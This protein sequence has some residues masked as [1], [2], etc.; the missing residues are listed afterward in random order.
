[1]DNR[2]IYKNYKDNLKS[3]INENSKPYS[4][5]SKLKHILK[6]PW[7]NSNSSDR[8]INSNSSNDAK[9]NT[10]PFKFSEPK[11]VSNP[12]FQKLSNI[13]EYKLPGSFYENLPIA[14]TTISKDVQTPNTTIIRLN[15]VPN[16]EEEENPNDILSDFFKRKGSNKLTDVEYEGVMSLISKSKSGTPYKRGILDVDQDTLGNDRKRRQISHSSF[17]HGNDT[18]ILES[19]P[20]KQKT[21][22]SNGNITI[23]YPESKFNYSTVNSTF[24]KSYQNINNTTMGR[25][26]SASGRSMY[27]HRRPAPYKSRMRGPIYT[28][29]TEQN[30]D[31]ANKTTINNTLLSQSQLKLNTTSNDNVKETP[32]SKTAQFLLSILD[33]NK[34]DKDKDDLN[35]NVKPTTN[36]FTNPYESSRTKKK[37]KSIVTQISSKDS[38]K[39][40]ATE[41]GTKSNSNFLFN[42][43]QQK[44]NEEGFLEKPKQVNGSVEENKDISI[45]TSTNS[46][47]KS[48]TFNFGTSTNSTSNL[49]NTPKTNFNFGSLK[50]SKEESTQPKFNFNPIPNSTTNSN[51]SKTTNGE[52]NGDQLTTTTTTKKVDFQFPTTDLVHVE[53][54]NAEVNKYKSLYSF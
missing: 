9:N 43:P 22:K 31:D 19:E 49:N 44:S 42:K 26:T 39:S 5:T 40:T 36:L 16:E 29:K 45:S 52:V 17:I 12:S 30:K 34:N 48:T 15:D 37:E 14:S 35:G 24:D 10:K 41:N 32:S 7:N 47:P 1:M 38:T 54:D 28:K 21:L 27:L 33:G 25:N 4:L 11:I 53:L 8:N 18:T 50:T 51:G 2:K 23:S 46:I 6:K 20:Y 13:K 3:N